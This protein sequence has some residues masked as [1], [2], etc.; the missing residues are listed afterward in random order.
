MPQQRCGYCANVRTLLNSS[1]SEAGRIGA[2]AGR[3]NKSPAIRPRTNKANL[4]TSVA[5]EALHTKAGVDGLVST[6]EPLRDWLGLQSERE[7]L[8]TGG[9]RSESG[10]G[11]AAADLLQSASSA[12][13]VRARLSFSH[14]KK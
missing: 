7:G 14:S 6:E 4:Q 12:V 8:K 10:S 2:Q 9:V 3:L 13:T 1:P 5:F 11:T